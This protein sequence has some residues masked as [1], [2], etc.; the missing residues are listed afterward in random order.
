MNYVVL[1]IQ[2]RIFTVEMMKLSTVST[3]HSTQTV[4]FMYIMIS[5]LKTSKI[6]RQNCDNSK[7]YIKKALFSA[8][9]AMLLSYIH[10]FSQIFSKMW[11][12]KLTGPYFSLFLLFTGV[13]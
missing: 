13:L 12:K 9:H 6:M 1:Y 7:I 10:K 3:A 2:F 5:M 11:S 8:G 4:T